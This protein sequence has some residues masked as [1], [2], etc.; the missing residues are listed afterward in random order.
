M[1]RRATT[2]AALLFALTTAAGAASPVGRWIATEIGGQP[3]ARGVETTLDLDLDG[4]VSGHGGCNRYGGT[5]SA[6]GDTIRFGMMQSTRMAC[7]APE[8]HQESRFHQ[9][10]FRAR[11]WRLEA[12]RLDL[13]DEAGGTV[14]RFLR[15]R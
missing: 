2:A 11:G 12:D 4:N 15:R 14:A 6:E 13:L 10:L 1:I 5:A 8:M 7:P 3:V 9:A